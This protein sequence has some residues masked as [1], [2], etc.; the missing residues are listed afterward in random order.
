MIMDA[1]ENLWQE[2]LSYPTEGFAQRVE[3]LRQDFLMMREYMLHGM[4]DPKRQELYQRLKQKMLD[5]CYDLEVRSGLMEYEIVK[6]YKRAV[7]NKGLSVEALQVQLV[8]AA[9]EKSHYESLTVAFF[10]LI[11]SYQ[12]KKSDMDD[13]TEFFVSPH[14]KPIDIATLV[15]ALSLSIMENYSEMKAQCLAQVYVR[16][17]SEL[18]RQRAFVGIMLAEGRRYLKQKEAGTLTDANAGSAAIE[19]LACSPDFPSALKEMFVQLLSCAN[20]RNDSQEVNKNIMPNIIKN[21]PFIITPGG[22]REKE[23]GKNADGTEAPF[24]PKADEEEER[25]IE[26]MEKSVEKM[27]KMQSKGADIFFSGFSQMKRFSFFYRAMNWFIPFYKEHPDIQ[28]YVQ[29]MGQNKFLE[30][31]NERGPFCESDKYSFII[32]MCDVLKKA[33]EN[34]KKMMENG[35]LGPIGM[36]PEGK[37]VKTASFLRLQYLQDLYRFY[38]LCPMGKEIYNPFSD[39]LTCACWLC[40]LGCLSDTDKKDMCLFLINRDESL[41]ARRVTIKIL[42]SF[43]DR[44]SFDRCFCHAELKMLQKDYPAAITQYNKCLTLKANDKAVMRSLA[45]AYYANGDYEKSAFIFDALHT[46]KPD[47]MSYQLNYAMAMTKA[48]K[49]EEVINMLFKLEYENPDNVTVSNTLGWSLMYVGRKEQALTALLK[50]ADSE[51][52]SQNLAYAYLFNNNI[53]EAVKLLHLLPKEHRIDSMRDDADLLG[54]YDIGEAE[55]AIL[56]AD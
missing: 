36:F 44:E 48:G 4:K 11:V 55:M 38:Q 16:S 51:A 46:M 2:S 42:N 19:M 41:S 12:W 26:A 18:V 23:P 7:I 8:N 35:E 22:I 13:W 37:D 25:N 54:K 47:N 50:H 20:A 5:L 43:K 17:Q 27:M 29:E 53:T 31:V 10:A 1:I 52:V 49:G 39:L 45:R 15:S 34:V 21:Q 3:S 30:R 32:A 14:I 40:A 28:S 9:D 24:D 33:P 56:A 6:P